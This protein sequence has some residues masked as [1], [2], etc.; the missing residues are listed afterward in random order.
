M[1]GEQAQGERTPPERCWQRPAVAERPHEPE[2]RPGKPGSTG[3]QVQVAQVDDEVIAE[4][5]GQGGNQRCRPR[6]RKDPFPPS[7]GGK[8]VHPNPGEH[9]VPQ[10][11]D[12]Q[13]LEGELEGGA[14][15]SQVT[16]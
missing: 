4:Q 11:E 7:E 6:N 3:Y 1:A 13:Q 8:G 10:H 12:S 14:A 2:Q 5:V 9:E 15:S 16:G